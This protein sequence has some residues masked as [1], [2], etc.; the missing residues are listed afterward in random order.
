ME[1]V[2]RYSAPQLS[3]TRGREPDV[4]GAGS[5]GSQTEVCEQEGLASC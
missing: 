2:R 5:T 4:T 3:M 1:K